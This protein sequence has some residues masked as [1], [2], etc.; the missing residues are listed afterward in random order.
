MLLCMR[1]RGT[2]WWHIDEDEGQRREGTAGADEKPCVMPIADALLQTRR[3]RNSVR[4]NREAACG[5][6]TLSRASLPVVR[7]FGHRMHEGT[8]W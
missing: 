4:L 6:F 7:H 1:E 8:R 2:R 5:A 3:R